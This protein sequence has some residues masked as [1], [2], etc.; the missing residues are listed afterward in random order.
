M[1][2]VFND[3]FSYFYLKSTL[4][5]S[6]FFKNIFVTLL[7]QVIMRGIVIHI[8]TSDRIVNIMYKYLIMASFL[9]SFKKASD[10][11]RAH[12]GIL[13]DEYATYS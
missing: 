10:E 5:K 8:H 3:S 6:K 4:R 12:E 13:L 11:I 1:K 9:M 2:K 7:W